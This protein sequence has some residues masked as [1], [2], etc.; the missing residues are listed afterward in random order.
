LW[1]A[2]LVHEANGDLLEYLG[3]QVRKLPIDLRLGQEV[4]PDLVRQL[5]PDVI[6]VAVGARRDRLPI[7][8]ADR[9]NVLSGD[10]LRILMTGAD[11]KTAVEKLTLAQRALLKMGGLLGV[12]DRIALTRELSKHWMPLGRRVAVIGGGLVGLELGEFLVERGRQVSIIDEEP[13]MGGEM[14]IPRRWQALGTLRRHGVTL[15]TG[16]TVDAIT[17]A[18][19][20]YTKDGQQQTVPADSIILAAGTQENRGLAEELAGLGIELHLLGD[21]KGVGYIEGAIL[22]GARI[23][24]AI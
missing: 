8:G 9:S 6:L 18:G 5:Q 16:A 20:L 1:F 23:A 10:D 13:V 14:A 22:D 2:S 24:R 12:S 19:V 15:V 21:C 4:T 7:P 17:D 11:K 3:H